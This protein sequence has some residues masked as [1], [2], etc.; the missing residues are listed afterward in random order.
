MDIPNAQIQELA[1]TLIFS[2][3]AGTLQ[4]D[5]IQQAM[6]LSYHMGA[7][8]SSLKACDTFAKTLKSPPN[9]AAQAEL[10]G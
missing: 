4:P 2:L 9:E 7:C 3:G 10:R 1:S 8:D 5:A 6:S